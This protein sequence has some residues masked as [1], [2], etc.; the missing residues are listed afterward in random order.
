MAV[1]SWLHCEV[2]VTDILVICNWL[3]NGLYRNDVSCV[4]IKIN[5]YKRRKSPSN[6]QPFSKSMYPQRRGY[7]L[8]RVV[9]IGRSDV[10]TTGNTHFF[11][12]MWRQSRQPRS[13]FGRGA[14]TYL[15]Y[16]GHDAIR[17]MFRYN[18]IHFFMSVTY[19]FEIITK[20]IQQKSIWNK[21]KE[22]KKHR[23]M[24]CSAVQKYVM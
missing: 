21:K 12:V 8:L 2:T 7:Y 4:Y 6:K 14:F 20:F 18:I 13:H 9:S 11:Y 10:I 19:Y 5:T 16:M 15:S 24:H 23:N 1:I 3:Q 22:G 17:D